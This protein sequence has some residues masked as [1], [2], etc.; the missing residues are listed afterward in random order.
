MGEMFCEFLFCSVLL[1][2]PA[3]VL[4]LLD[5]RPLPVWIFLCDLS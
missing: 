3:F 2:A 1:E 5:F 4:E